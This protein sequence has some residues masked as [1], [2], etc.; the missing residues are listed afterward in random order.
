[1][2]NKEIIQRDI[3]TTCLESKV[4]EELYLPLPKE[5]GLANNG[6]IILNNNRIELRVAVRVRLHRSLHGLKQAGHNWYNTLE[7]YFTKEM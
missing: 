6:N 5:F 4:E 2:E 1:M 3:V 7:S